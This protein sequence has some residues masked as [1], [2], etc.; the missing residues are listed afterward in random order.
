MARLKP[1]VAAAMLSSGA[2]LAEPAAPV[3][4]LEYAF[5]A[6]VK[7]APG[8]KVSATSTVIATLAP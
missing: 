4:N 6:T 7:V 5:T 2:A 3:P 8:D 1:L